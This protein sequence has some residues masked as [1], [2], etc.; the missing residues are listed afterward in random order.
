[1]SNEMIIFVAFSIATLVVIGMN[2]FE[3]GMYKYKYDKMVSIV[4]CQ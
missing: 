3:N 4:R 1:M 2:L